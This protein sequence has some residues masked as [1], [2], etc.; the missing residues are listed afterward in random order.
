MALDNLEQYCQARSFSVQET[1]LRML[2][3]YWKD[4]GSLMASPRNLRRALRCVAQRDNASSESGRRR[5]S[6]R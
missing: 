6:I 2:R 3:T 1:A 4:K 5:T